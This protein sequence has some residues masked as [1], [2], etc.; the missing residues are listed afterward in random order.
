MGWTLL[1]VTTFDDWSDGLARPLSKASP[2]GTTCLFII[3][4]FGGLA[5]LNIVLAITV[6]STL[7][8]AKVQKHDVNVDL[9]EAE[10]ELF[11]VMTEEFLAMDCGEIPSDSPAT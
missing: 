4:A 8:A 7:H 5:I 2:V 10:R 1:Q 9:E 11:Q 3:M 6:E